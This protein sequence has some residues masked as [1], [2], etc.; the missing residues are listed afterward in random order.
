MKKFFERFWGPKPKIKTSDDI[1]KSEHFCIIPW[2]HL[3]ALPDS[4]V[5]PCC[6]SEFNHTYGNLKESSLKEIWNNSKFKSMRKTMLADKPV[7]SCHKCYELE[8]SGVHTMRKRMN[9]DFHSHTDLLTQTKK[10]GYLKNPTM[11][12]LDFRFSNI[13]NFKC[14]G[15]SPDLSTSWYEDHQ[16]LWNFKSKKPK[17]MNALNDNDKL[18]NELEQM[19]PTVEQA[20]FAGGEPLLMEEHYKCLEFFINHKMSHVKLSYN[21][22]LSVLKFKKYDLI[23]MWKQFSDVDI[24]VSIDDIEERGEYFRAGLRWDQLVH[25]LKDVHEKIP[26]LYIHINCTV[27][28]FNIHRIPEIHQKLFS[29][30]IFDHEGFKL[31]T[32]LD[33]VEYRCQV[34]PQ[35]S[36]AEISKKL[37]DYADNLHVLYPKYSEEKW[38]FLKNQI[39]QQIEFFNAEDLEAKLRDFKNL[40]KSLDKIRDVNFQQTYPELQS[41]L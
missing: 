29:L 41:F 17:L 12:Y 36:K 40:T 9:N 2:L 13:C 19:L 5:L 1:I 34:I 7:S 10:D 27:S 32:L 25:N 20:Y 3:H 18:W 38:Q 31:N 39:Y 8:K 4:R 21:S 14:R 24:M 16:K 37:K 28:I 35:K 11:R 33:P 23:K 15:C 30:D 6:V 26:G 22:N